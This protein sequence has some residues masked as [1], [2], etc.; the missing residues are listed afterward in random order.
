MFI[1]E[2]LSFEVK[3][4]MQLRKIIYFIFGGSRSLLL[5]VALFSC[6][7]QGPFLGAWTSHCGGFSC[8]RAWALDIQA[9]SVAAHGLSICGP[10]TL[11]HRLSG[12]CTWAHLHWGMWHLNSWTRNPTHVPCID[13]FPITGPLGKFLS[14][15]FLSE[16]RW[17]YTC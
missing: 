16:F 2:N 17:I 7:K 1:S 4:S 14:I 13:R 9:S 6:N 11:E 15:S 5:Y 3:P 10:Q 12:C 8:S